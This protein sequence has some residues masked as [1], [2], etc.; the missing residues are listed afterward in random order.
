MVR[1]MVTRCVAVG[2]E[3]VLFLETKAGSK[4]SLSGF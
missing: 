2:M 4:R 1:G 3:S